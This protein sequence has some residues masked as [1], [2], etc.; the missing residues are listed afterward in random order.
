MILSDDFGIDPGSNAIKIFDMDNGSFY[1]LPNALAVTREGRVTAWGEEA[2]QMTGT[3]PKSIS[4]RSSVR[5]GKIVDVLLLDQILERALYMNRRFLG[6]RPSLYF[7]VPAEMTEI[8]RRAYSSV[9]KRGRLKNCD[10]YLLERAFAEAFALGLP[11]KSTRG[12]MILD[13]GDSHIAASVV[14]GGRIILERAIPG[15]GEAFSSAVLT[16]I[17]K[18]NNLIIGTLTAEKLKMDLCSL[19]TAD[20]T[21][22]QVAGLDSQNGLPR[23]GFVTSRTINEAV[24]DQLREVI[25]HL[26]DFI[27][28]IPPQILE[29]VKEE[30]IY[31][32][33]G[34][35]RI[36]GIREFLMEALNVPMILSEEYEYSVVHG[37]AK[38]NSENEL[39]NYARIPEIRQRR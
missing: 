4:I 1:S 5:A 13:L 6:I 29:S 14:S 26:E 18:K 15:G 8:E 22:V 36:P 3:T 37:I 16:A 12:I 9:S 34:S 17:R 32:T 24:K 30:G 19:C 23:D 10:V 27:H 31:L 2:R 39:K 28:R 20:S 35:S 11:I 25:L 38:M 33:G 21:G 7:A